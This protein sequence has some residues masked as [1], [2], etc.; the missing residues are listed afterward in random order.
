MK[1][2]IHEMIELQD[3]MN[4]KVDIDWI[5]KIESGIGRYGSS[6]ENSWSTTE[7]GN[8]GKRREGFR[9]NITRIG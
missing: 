6:V 7:A 1:K 9:T 2:L 4:R 5:E 8:G 3:A